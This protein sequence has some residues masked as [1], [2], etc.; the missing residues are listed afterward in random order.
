MFMLRKWIL[1]KVAK[2]GDAITVFTSWPLCLPK[3]GAPHKTNINT[4]KRLSQ[5][6]IAALQQN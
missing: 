4:K 5:V 2:K 6:I 3:N 1:K